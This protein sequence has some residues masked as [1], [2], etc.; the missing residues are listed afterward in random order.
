M[1]PP[2][3][4]RPA[5]R[6]TST[7]QKRTCRGRHAAFG[8][9]ARR[10]SRPPASCREGRVTARRLPEGASAF[11]SARAAPRVAGPQGAAPPPPASWGGRGS[12]PRVARWLGPSGTSSS[13]TAGCPTT[14]TRRAWSSGAPGCWRTWPEKSTSPLGAASSQRWSWATAGSEWPAGGTCPWFGTGCRCS[15][16]RTWLAVALVPLPAGGIAWGQ[17]RRAALRWPLCRRRRSRRRRSP[18]SMRSWRLPGPSRTSSQAPRWGHLR[19][20]HTPSAPRRSP[21]PSAGASGPPGERAAA[22]RLGASATQ[23]AVEAAAA[24]RLLAGI[25]LEGSGLLPQRPR[26]SSRSRRRSSGSRSRTRRSSRGSLSSR[27]RSRCRRNS[28]S[29]GKSSRCRRRSNFIR[30]WNSSVSRNLSNPCRQ[31]EGS[32]GSLVRKLLRSTRPRRQSGIRAT[33]WPQA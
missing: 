11:P 33:R 31:S 4:L 9:A 29:P 12:R 20:R 28:R 25:R 18:C 27:T 30:K 23:A 13:T 10:T 32:C 17:A 3:L 7:R 24:L 5:S 21:P 14:A 6:P 26:R 8:G 19:P 22:R 1:V 2:R 15:R 16:H